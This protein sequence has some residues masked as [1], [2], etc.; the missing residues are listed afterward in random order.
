MLQT[1][2]QAPEFYGNA[3]LWAMGAVNDF[4]EEHPKAHVE[5]VIPVVEG[6]KELTLV[7]IDIQYTES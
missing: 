6:Q 1:R 2:I 5:E 3:K 7:A 4:K